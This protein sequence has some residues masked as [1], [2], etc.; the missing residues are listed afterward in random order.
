M[1]ASVIRL[2]Q[3]CCNHVQFVFQRS[4]S[5]SIYAI[6]IL[7]ECP[8]NPPDVGTFQPSRSVIRD[9]FDM[10]SIMSVVLLAFDINDI[11]VA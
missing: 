7:L 3:S 8:I 6:A 4:S 9:A 5:A 10:R 1:K 11:I 2:V